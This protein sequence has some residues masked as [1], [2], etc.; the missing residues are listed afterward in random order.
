MAHPGAPSLHLLDKPV[1]VKRPVPNKS[2][3]LETPEQVRHT[4]E[5][6]GLPRKKDKPH[7]MAKRVRDR[8]CPARQTPAGTANA[9]FRGPPR[10]TEESETGE[11]VAVDGI[12]RIYRARL[13]LSR[14]LSLPGSFPMRDRRR[15]S[16][17]AAVRGLLQRGFRMAGRTDFPPGSQQ[18]IRAKAW[19][20]RHPVRLPGPGWMPGLRNRTVARMGAGDHDPSGRRHRRR[21]EHS[22][23]PPGRERLHRHRQR[24]RLQE[25]CRHP[26]GGRREAGRHGGHGPDASRRLPVSP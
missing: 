26:A 17:P 6:A 25:D 1:R 16:G 4:G 22:Q 18:R 12:A 7:K 21:R 8:H 13:R 24:G 23:H 20:A 14:P 11:R 10:M 3:E 9:L 19:S 15:R 5:V 2:P